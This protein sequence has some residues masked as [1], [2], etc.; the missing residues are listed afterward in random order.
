MN[1]R[2][3]LFWKTLPLELDTP[4]QMLSR[5]KPY[6]SKVQLT[7]NVEFKSAN[8]MNFYISVKHNESFI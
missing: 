3:D 5:E 8:C 7:K 2:Y 1:N 6:Y 4:N